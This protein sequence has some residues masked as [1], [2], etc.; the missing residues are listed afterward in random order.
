MHEMNVGNKNQKQKYM[1][2]HCI[3]LQLQPFIPSIQTWTQS[4]SDM[5]AKKDKAPFK[6]CVCM[7]AA[8]LGA[9]L[10]SPGGGKGGTGFRR[11]DPIKT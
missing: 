9:D 11:P 4:N 7:C 1:L 3:F 8:L 6:V 10:A 2:L 5:A